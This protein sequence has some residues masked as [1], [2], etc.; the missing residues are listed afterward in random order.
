M[1]QDDGF[2]KVLELISIDCGGP[3]PCTENPFYVFPEMKLRGLVPSSYI[4]VFVSDLYF[5]RIGL[6]ILLQQ[7]RQPRDWEYINRLQMH[8]C[9]NRETEH[10]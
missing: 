8:E 1:I 7:I 10:Y 9:G 4:H 5:A 3:V 6:P 2:C